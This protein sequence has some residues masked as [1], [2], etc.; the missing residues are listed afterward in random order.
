MSQTD[1]IKE[2]QDLGQRIDELLA[3]ADQMLEESKQFFQQQGI[4]REMVTNFL[5]HRVSSADQAMV[6]RELFTWQQELETEQEQARLSAKMQMRK[7][8]HRLA[9]MCV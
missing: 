2:A 1:T 9:R 5:R 4:S 7:P 3:Q 8:R 6:R